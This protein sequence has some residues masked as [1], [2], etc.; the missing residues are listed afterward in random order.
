MCKEGAC[1][2][3]GW[4]QPG[5]RGFLGL[6]WHCVHPQ[7][8]SRHRWVRPSSH[9]CCCRLQD[10]GPHLHAPPPPSPGSASPGTASRPRPEPRKSE[11]SAEPRKEVRRRPV[12]C[13]CFLRQQACGVSAPPELEWVARHGLT[14]GV[15]GMEL[16][17]RFCVFSKALT[18]ASGRQRRAATPPL[19]VAGTALLVPTVCSLPAMLLLN[20]SFAPRPPRP[21]PTLCAACGCAAPRSA[22]PAPQPLASALRRAPARPQPGAG[23]CRV[24]GD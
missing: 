10:R 21:G 6:R 23:G 11:A 5:V 13:C 18:A 15:P 19:I 16:K 9:S 7:H 17:G 2:G 24:Q 22:A 14:R 4:L 20:P 3:A 12:A 1:N 8:V